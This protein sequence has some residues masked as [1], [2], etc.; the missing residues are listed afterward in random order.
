VQAAAGS[1]EHLL[2]KLVDD[3][4]AQAAGERVL[5]AALESQVATE[6]LAMEK[7]TVEHATLR[8]NYEHL[9]MQMALLERR[10]FL[11]KAERIDTAQLELE[12]T[13]LRARL[14]TSVGG[15]A[16]GVPE[17]TEANEDS[18]QPKENCK[19]RGRRDLSLSS[20][21]QERIELLDEALEAAGAE[22]IGFEESCRLGMKR[23]GAFC[24]VVA[25]VKYKVAEAAGSI[26]TAELPKE[27][28]SRAMCAPSMIANLLVD[29]FADGL[30]FHRQEERLARDGIALHRSIMCRM[31]ED[32]GMTLGAIVLAARDHAMANSFCLSTDATG[33]SVAPTRIADGSRQ[34][35]RK[36]HFFVTLADQEHVFFS[37]EPKHTSTAVCALFAGYKGYIQADASSVYHRLFN[38]IVA[39]GSKTSEDLPSEVGCMAHARRKFFE[40]AITTKDPRA[41]EALMRIRMFFE[42]E[43]EWAKLAPAKRGVLRRQVLEPWLTEFFEWATGIYNSIKDVRGLLSD[44]FGYA[45]RQRAALC[46]FI[47]DGR[48]KIDNNAS[49]RALR[50]VAVGRKNWLFFGS[51]DHAEAAANLMSLIASCKLHAI[52]PRAY[53]E[54]V[55]RL[56][57]VWPRDRYIELAPMNWLRTRSRLVQSELDAPFGHMTL[58]AKE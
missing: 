9:R 55:I 34:A 17:A 8:K 57:P 49:E 16:I 44:A 2:L 25:R 56:V 3:L 21:P 33:V 41:R 47:E 30:P 38:G 26:V 51:D 48:L 6:R 45:V 7:L 18:T 43:A 39:D 31:A 5:R 42:K 4:H 35:C 11:A 10:I 32:V 54:A 40:A 53:L 36:G 28:V 46:T 24:I 37:Y 50:K 12:Y 27:I 15:P 22:R 14:E 58:P 23:G 19:P 52:E 20:L 29:K 1:H 13:E